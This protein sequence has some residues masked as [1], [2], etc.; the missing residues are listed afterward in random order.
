MTKPVEIVTINKIIPIYKDGQEANSIH[1]VNFTFR[2]GD[3]C[4]YNV[5]SQKGLY[6]IGSKAVYIQPDYCLSDISLFDSFIRPFGEIN[7]SK[8]G[9]N[10]RIRAVKF[11]F[12]F[13]KSMDPI[14]S[15]GILLPKTEVDAYLGK[16]CDLEDIDAVLGITKYEEPE[17]AGSG[18][19]VG[20]FPSFMY[21]TDE[22][23]INNIKSKV[24]AACDG[25]TE[26]GLTIKVDGS[27]FTQYFRKIDGVF[28]TGICSRSM[29]KKLEQTYVD[30]YI[31][32]GKIYHKYIHPETKI[33]GWYCD[34]LKDFKT[35]EEVQGFE[36]LL[37]EVKDSW[38]ELSK[39]TGL[40][41]NG[42]K[43]CMDNDVQL[44]FRGEIFGQGLKGSGNKF[45]PNS[46]D[47]QSLRIFGIDSLE[48]GFSIRQH[49]GNTHNV[50]SVCEAI[51]LDYTKSIIV[52][53]ASYEDLI[54]ICE[55][56]FKEEKNKGKVIE[57]IVIRTMYSNQISCK[58]MNA[59]YDSKK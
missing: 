27:S 31:N 45:N 4:G 46:N 41:D 58:H 7:K 53:P 6:E 32:N 44:V 23:N 43:Y 56:I 18:L 1:V 17:S 51:G 52:K 50:V 42:M 10:Y 11:N 9:K 13:E 48:N 34:E 22:E 57:G 40:F 39:S 36:M 59:E 2:N 29:E 28:T 37:V 24:A 12:S 30:K 19:A 8:L 25:N 16:D 33:K 35:D 14:Y 54:N 3:E 38:V 15:F 21:K 55:N 20:D 49:Y 26:F 5:I 47:K